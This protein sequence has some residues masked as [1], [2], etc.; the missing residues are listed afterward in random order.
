M[1]EKCEAEINT[2]I[3]PDI[4]RELCKEAYLMIKSDPWMEFK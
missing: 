1:K 3:S 4:G 2:D